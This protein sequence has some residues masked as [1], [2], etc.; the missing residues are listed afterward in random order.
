M[1]SL[2]MARYTR[3]N[4]QIGRNLRRHRIEAGA[5]QQ[6]LANILGRH[7]PAIS[8]VEAGRRA[9]TLPEAALLCRQLG[10]A[11]VDLYACPFDGR[12]KPRRLTRS[13]S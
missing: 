2:S 3:A 7:R 13:G 9:L 5:T 10:I 4:Q 12:V 11:V 6:E 1:Y 8:E